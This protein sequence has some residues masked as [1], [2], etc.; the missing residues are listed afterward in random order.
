MAKRTRRP[1]GTGS[2]RNRNGRWQGSF[3]EID[4]RTESRRQ[5]SKTFDTKTAAQEWITT[6]MAEMERNGPTVRN[7]DTLADFLCMWLDSRDV[8]E[9]AANT[10]SWYRSAVKDHIIPALGSIRLDKLSAAQVDAFLASRLK[11]GRLDGRPGG[12]SPSSVR[13]LYVTLRK[14]VTWGQRMNVLARD[15]M[16]GVSAPKLPTA[17]PLSKSWTI[18]QVETFLASVADDRLQALWH[19]AAWTG[20]RRGELVGL[21]WS[22][23]D[24]DGGAVSV[25]R[26][27]VM[28]DGLPVE[29]TPKTNRGRRVVELD[30]RTVAA[31]RKHRAAQVVERLAA[32]SAWHDKDDVFV[33]E[34]GRPLRPDWVSH[35]FGQLVRTAGLRPIPFSGLRD[36]HATALLRAGVHPKIVQERL[37][38]HSAAFTLDVY[39]AV[40]PAM[41]RDAVERL[42]EQIVGR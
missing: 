31:L 38:H 17:D 28:V 14:A 41:Q 7:H 26:T 39:S 5:I 20:M 12:L 29:S 4:P 37:G 21:R 36:T 10:K 22:D 27:V 24:L 6:T 18:E 23:V 30:D 1:K 34:D 19:T 33:W 11:G 13:R 32:G 35:R 42:S 40:I 15:P 16:R 9:L 2:I 25:R 8:T 3:F